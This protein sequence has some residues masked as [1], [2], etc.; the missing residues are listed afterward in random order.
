MTLIG[1][2][3]VVSI[4]ARNS[5]GADLLEEPGVEVGGVVH[6]HIDPA[7]P[8][9]RGLHRGPGVGGVGDVQGHRQQIVVLPDRGATCSGL[10]PVATTA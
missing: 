6:Q 8:V 3:R 10:R 4:W 9:D 5:A 1:P 2:N 7:E